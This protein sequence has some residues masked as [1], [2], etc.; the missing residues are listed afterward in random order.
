M[1]NP[2]LTLIP[3]NLHYHC[4][5]CDKKIEL[6][7]DAIARTI[8]SPPHQGVSFTTRGNWGSQIWDMSPMVHAVIC[9]KC[10]VE[11]SHRMLMEE[12]ESGKIKVIKVSKRLSSWF[13]WLTKD[14]GDK[15]S[16]SYYDTVFSYFENFKGG[17]K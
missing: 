9:D 10:F 2:K 14:K 12:T 16:D 11:K 15:P 17:G 8:N 1:K 5:V 13:D 3:K 4:L 6:Y 7:D